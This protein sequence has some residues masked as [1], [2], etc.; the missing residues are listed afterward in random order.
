[1][2]KFNVLLAVLTL[3]LLVACGNQTSEV[4]DTSNRLVIAIDNE[5][6]EGFDPCV[7][8]GRYSAPLFQSTL[9]T[10]D[11]DM[12]I[13]YDLA[14]GYTVSDDGLVWTFDLRD[15]VLFS[16]DKPLTASDVVFT[17]ET[18]ATSGSVVDLTAMEQV[19]ANGDY[20]VTFHL[21][22]PQSTFLYTVAAT[23][24]VSM[25]DYDENYYAN[26][27][28][29][30]P[31]RM[32]Q[33][34]KGQQVIIEPNPN[35][36]GIQSP[37]EQISILFMSE[38]TAFV[39]AEKGEVDVAITNFN[40]AENQVEGM[41]LIA[42]PTIDNRGITLPMTPNTG[43]LTATGYPIGN[44]VT[45]DLAIRQAL[46]LGIDRDALVSDCLDGYAVPAFSECDGMPWGNDA[47]EVEYDLELALKTLEDRGWILNET[48]GIREKDGVIASF[49]ILYSAGSLER[50][51][52]SF[53]ASNQAKLLGI[54]IL[55][56]GVSWDEIDTRMYS[57]AVLMGW[58]SQNPM[59]G[60]YLYH[61]INK[62]K[63]YYNPENYDNP[64]VDA[65]LEL[66]LTDHENA[67]E[68]FQ[69]SKWDGE[70]GVAADLPWVWLVNLDHLYFVNENLDT[71]E[72]KIHPHGQEWP[73]LEN[74]NE[75][76]WKD[77][78]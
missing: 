65:Y 76:K 46:N 37:F 25:E 28:G 66:A 58:G 47:L 35:Y 3:V 5:P 45:S 10:F 56:E 73:V 75:W 4:A 61:S 54:E 67:M 62:G 57:N 74:L 32:L 15:D 42:F 51:S 78:A 53:A 60:Y 70:S 41:E 40:Y 22:Q 43:E 64:Q 26:P 21:K 29:S 1:M 68:W 39:A 59:E 17:F 34:D 23:G 44:D 77:E 52:L 13:T 49:T 38:E 71:G 6:D 12:N 72:Q 27:V 50:Q 31:F 69:K 36:Y 33:W 8:W 9:I 24:I 55:V 30:G 11:K 20:Q 48:T 18:T 7:G 14:T 63:D 19:V 2:R 16:N